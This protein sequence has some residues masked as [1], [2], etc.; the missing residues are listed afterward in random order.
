MQ[1]KTQIAAFILGATFLASP[2][3]W[4]QE[5]TNVNEDTPKTL[6]TQQVKDKNI[7]RSDWVSFDEA[8]Q[9]LKDAGYGEIMLLKQTGNGYFARTRDEDGMFR[10][11][12]IDPKG[13][14]NIKKQYTKGNQRGPSKQRGQ[15]GPR[16]PH[17]QQ[18]HGQQHHH[19]H[20][21][22]HHQQQQQQQQ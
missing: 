10:H 13:E 11:I 20:Q 12:Y 6:S 15:R 21:P 22:Q 4:A 17:H 18:H 7:D 9:K 5:K 8:T 16:G 3:T 2:L 1:K 14:I 19:Q